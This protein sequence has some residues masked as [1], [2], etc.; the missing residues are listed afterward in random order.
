MGGFDDDGKTNLPHY[1]GH[2]DRLRARFREQGPASLVDYELLELLLFRSIP[3][4]DTKP[5]A[6]ALIAACGSFAE[7]IGASE[8]RLRAV[9]GVGDAVVTDLKLVHAAAQRMI[10]G[11]V[12]GRTVLGTWSS[13]IDYC[14]AAM[15][16]EEK[17]QFR[18]LFLDKKNALIIDEVQQ[19]GTVDHT[20][21][22]PREVVKRA[23]ELSAT[24]IILVHNHP[25]GDPTPSRADIQMTRQI[26]DVARP[27]GI[28]VH[29]HIIVGRDGH[30]SLKGLQLI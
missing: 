15:A 8:A 21:V 11:E 3:R 16:F 29:D 26:I 23:L 17:E 2:R 6:K 22:Y 27:L 19:V 25:S 18:I 9:P 12:I 13:V 30:A 14:R 7:V 4:Q 24:A 5:I 20:P 28:A 10:R 1:H